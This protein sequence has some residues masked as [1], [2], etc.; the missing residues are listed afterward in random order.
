V[1]A[2]ILLGTGAGAALGFSAGIFSLIVWTFVQPHIPYAFVFTPFGT[3]GEIR[4]NGWSIFISVVP[5]IMIGVAAGVSYKL[6]SRLLFRKAAIDKKS[7]KDLIAY[8]AAG[9]IGSLTNTFLVL[10]SIYLFFGEKYAASVN[11]PYEMLIMLI[12]GTVATNGIP[13]AIVSALCAM[14]I[15]RPIKIIQGKRG[16]FT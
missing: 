15:C 10:G 13:E 2:A 5:R 1:I 11:V 14:F 9:V 7:K 8:G 16:D 4:G 6:I 12:F 3:L